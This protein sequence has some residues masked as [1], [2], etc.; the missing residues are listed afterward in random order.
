VLSF[1]LREGAKMPTKQLNVRLPGSSL[2]LLNRLMKELGMTQV[3]VI[4]VALEY[5]A[6]SKKVK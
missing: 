4:V 5:L 2:A 3:Q 6:H 1:V